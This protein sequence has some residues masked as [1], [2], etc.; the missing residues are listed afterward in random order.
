L[1]AEVQLVEPAP[2]F[3]EQSQARAFWDEKN[4]PTIMMIGVR[5]RY[6]VLLV[7]S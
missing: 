5:R 1:A 4:M 6:G 2:F 7:R 3:Q